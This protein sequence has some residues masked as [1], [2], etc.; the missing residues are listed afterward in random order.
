MKRTFFLI[1]ALKAHAKSLFQEV[2]WSFSFGSCQS[3][4]HWP[5]WTW[6]IMSCE[7]QCLCQNFHDNTLLLFPCHTKSFWQNDWIL[8]SLKQHLA[9]VNW[10]SF[11]FKGLLPA[12][13]FRYHIWNLFLSSALLLGTLNILPQNM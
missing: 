9:T 1:L 11:K 2:C 13:N 8:S 5:A 3:C 7:L 6:A 4:S 12:K 10:T